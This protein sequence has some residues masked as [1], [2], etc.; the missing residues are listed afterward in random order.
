MN[1]HDTRTVVEAYFQALSEGRMGDAARHVSPDVKRWVSGEGSWPFGGHQDAA[2]MAHIMG[3]VHDRFP[4]GVRLAVRT[5]TVEGERASVEASGAMR[6][7]DGRMYTNA[8][9]YVLTVTG[10]K[11]VE[12]RE[13]LDTIHAN[14]L[15][16]G[17]M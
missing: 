7:R 9:C 15:M 14:D 16:C 4:E 17:P 10:G 6:R 11:I 3:V 12:V 5:I 2:G 8:Y 13:Y 1:S